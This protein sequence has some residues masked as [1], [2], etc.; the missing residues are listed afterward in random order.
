MRIFLIILSIISL[1]SCSKNASKSFTSVFIERVFTDSLSIRAIEPMDVNKVWFAAN[2]GKV[3]LIDYKTPKLATIKYEDSLLNFRAISSINNAVFVIS[4]ENP[5][6]L[7]KIGFKENNATSIEDVYTEKG[8]NVFYDAIKFWDDKEGIAMGDPIG[9]C[10]SILVT[11]DAGNNWNKLPCDMLP[12]IVKG[13]A[14]FAASNSNISVY[15]NHVWIVTGGKKARVFHSSDRGVTWE[16][17]ETPI[18]QGKSMTGIYSVDFLDDNA[19]TALT[20]AITATS[21]SGARSTV[22]IYDGEGSTAAVNTITGAVGTANNR[23]GTLQIGADSDGGSAN[24]NG[25]VA[26]TNLNINSGTATNESSL[27]AFAAAIDAVT[28]TLTD[29]SAALTATLELDENA[30][31]TVL[32]TID[33]NADNKGILKIS[34]TGKI[35][36]GVVGGINPLRMVDLN[37]LTTFSSD[38]SSLGLDLAAGKLSHVKW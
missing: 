34:G 38:V 26:V 4:I 25:A 8:K 20:G 19:I 32:G 27:G 7:Y 22:R 13:E 5:G 16:V 12:E 24:I 17:F 21:T 1:I 28:I 6:V 9:G 11:R 33:G 14:A 29:A 3:G 15:K 18:I 23:I 30:A 31:A 36:S 2:N 10:L 35:I 37:E